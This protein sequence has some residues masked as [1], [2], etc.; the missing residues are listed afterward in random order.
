MKKFIKTVTITGAD[1]SVDPQDLV[2]LSEEFS[3]VEWGILLSESQNGTNRFPNFAWIEELK[4]TWIKNQNLFLSGHICGKWV[5]DI[6][7]GD[8]SI[9]KYKTEQD[10]AWQDMFSRFQLNF[11][12]QVHTLNKTEFLNGFEKNKLYRAVAGSEFIFQLDDVNNKILDVAIENGINAFG[13]FDLSGGA[14]I[15][16]KNWP[17]SDKFCGYSGGLSPENLAE[18]LQLIEK[19]ATNQIWIDVE[20]HVRSNNDT[21]FDLNK[22]KKF[23]EISREWVI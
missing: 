20:T 14:G 7:C 4:N 2:K 16:P 11:H 15:L 12:A 9:L 1:N 22:V 3:F 19:V 18:Q 10:C 17:T 8:W 21:Q 13:L 23:L 6:C 5:R